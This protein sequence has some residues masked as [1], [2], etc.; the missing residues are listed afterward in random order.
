MMFLSSLLE[1]LQK[2]FT[3][4]LANYPALLRGLTVT[5]LFNQHHYQYRGYNT[6]YIAGFWKGIW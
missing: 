5:I 1:G 6:R 4:F 3:I 2:N